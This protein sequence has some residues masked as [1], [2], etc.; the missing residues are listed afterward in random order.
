MTGKSKRLKDSFYVQ[1]TC[2]LSSGLEIVVVP[3]FVIT[4][5]TVTFEIVEEL[6]NVIR[7]FK[8]VG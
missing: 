6:L 4:S 8:S 5:S 3:L 7:N 2:Q 1:L